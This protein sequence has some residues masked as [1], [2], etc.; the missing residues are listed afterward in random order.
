MKTFSLLILSI[1]FCNAIFSQDYIANQWYFGE[2]CGVDFSTTP[3]TSLSGGQITGLEGCATIGDSQGNLLFYSD[4]M[5]VYNANHDVME[6][7]DNLTGHWSSAQSALILPVLFDRNSKLYYLFTLDDGG[8]EHL[9]DGWRYSIIDMSENGGLGAVTEDKNILIEE[10]MTERQVAVPHSNQQDIWLI[11]HRWESNEFVAYLISSQGIS[12]TPVV[13]AV[14]SVHEGGWSAN[15]DYNGWVNAA[16]FIKA[17]LQ[18]D[19]LAVSQ[20]D[21]V[22]ELFDFD[23]STGIV[24][25]PRTSVTF[26]RA[27]GIEFSPDGTKLYATY[28]IYANAKLIQFD[29]SQE[30]PMSSYTTIQTSYSR[31]DALQLGPNGKIYVAKEGDYYLGEISNPNGSGE[32]CDYISEGIYLGGNQCS[33]GLPYTYYYPG[34]PGFDNEQSTPMEIIP[35]SSVYPNPVKD[36]LTITLEGKFS[37]EVYNINCQFID[38]IENLEDSFN[39]NVSDYSPATYL[40]KVNLDNKQVIKKFIKL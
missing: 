8:A 1:I 24:S 15:P 2:N 29:L 30:E 22:I 6:N 21:A 39:L 10:M 16:G 31:L 38:R 9:A 36:N 11:G 3:P 35:L 27:F 25:N 20:H 28:D 33:Y 19:K 37:L 17:S 5:N 4:G 32:D 14:G 13:S 7:G 12:E 23:N 34:Y 26:D 40:I 18:W